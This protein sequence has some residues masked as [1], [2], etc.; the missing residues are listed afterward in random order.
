L[1][2]SRSGF[3]VLGAREIGSASV[4]PSTI[5]P[6]ISANTQYAPAPLFT[7]VLAKKIS[8][9]LNAEG[10]LDHDE[11]TGSYD[12]WGVGSRYGG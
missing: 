11:F 9:S 10:S 8:I 3:E 1:L 7:V 6:L 2:N 4:V 5:D 12:H